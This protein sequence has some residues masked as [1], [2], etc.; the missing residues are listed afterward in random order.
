M[1]R[2][3]AR[4]WLG[5]QRRI[6]LEHTVLQKEDFLALIYYYINHDSSQSNDGMPKKQILRTRFFSSFRVHD[7]VYAFRWRHYH[8]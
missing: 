7:D 8:A 1:T 2:W 5:M 6:P 3:Y 4:N